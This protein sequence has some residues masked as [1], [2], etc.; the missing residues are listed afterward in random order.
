[1]AGV[2]YRVTAIGRAGSPVLIAAPH[3]GLI[4]V[5]TSEIAQTI[6]GGDYSLFLFE[7]LKPY[8]T[9]RV[10]H[11]TSHRFDHPEFLALAAGCETVISVH[12]C[13]GETRIHIGGLDEEL[14]AMLAAQV[15][16]A[17]FPVE[18][19]SRRYPGRHPQNIC[20]RGLRGRGAQLEVTYDL[21]RGQ[22]RAAI[23]RAVRS[24]IA[25]RFGHMRL[26]TP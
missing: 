5:G 13:L 1:M 2:D 9:N 20:N 18:A 3:G 25:A 16:K 12:G 21:R 6:A 4:E 26:D 24:A 11:I 23:A 14:A 17:E 8:G 22:A 7:G 15:S 19:P 10:L